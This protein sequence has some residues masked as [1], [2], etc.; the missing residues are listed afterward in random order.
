MFIIT[1]FIGCRYTIKGT[2]YMQI[3]WQFQP[4]VDYK[5]S[6]RPNDAGRRHNAT[7][8]RSFLYRLVSVKLRLLSRILGVGSSGS[9]SQ[10]R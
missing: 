7:L 9:G 4:V 1:D 5:R 8:G 6:L 10:S 3:Y 2:K